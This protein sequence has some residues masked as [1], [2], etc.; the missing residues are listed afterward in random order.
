M[1][2]PCPAFLLWLTLALC[3]YPGEG[4]WLQASSRN[5]APDAV[6]RATTYN[7]YSGDLA[8]LQDGKYPPQE[9]TPFFWHTKGI[10]TFEWQGELPLEK[11]GIFVGEI[12]N[13]FQLRA[14]RGGHL[15]ETGT[16][17]EPEG[18]RSTLLEENSRLT[19]QWV[20]I[21][22]G[23]GVLADNLELRALGSV[24]IYEVE[25]YVRTGQTAVE[26]L[27]WGQVKALHR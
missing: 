9:A 15:D 17:R 27:G 25:I 18:E 3:L 14:Y 10:L 16:V 7:T 8:A 5:L 13:N 20:Q 1:Y 6:S 23:E 2:I 12:G 26:R 11:V 21:P 22:F 24:V 19:D 4:D